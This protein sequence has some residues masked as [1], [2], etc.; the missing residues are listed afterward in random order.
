MT[1]NQI[2]RLHQAQPFQPFRNHLADGR[3][4][5]VPHPEML[6]IMPPGRTVFVATGEEDY[7]IVDLLLVAS[8]EVVNGRAGPGRRRR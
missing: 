8:L 7:E 6:A 3:A 5:D 4:L 1:V 2:R